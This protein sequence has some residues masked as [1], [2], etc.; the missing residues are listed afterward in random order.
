MGEPVSIATAAVSATSAACKVS[1]SL[2][3]FISSA[4]KVDKTIELLYTAV[5]RLEGSLKNVQATLQSENI[6]KATKKQHLYQ[7]SL[8]AVEHSLRDCQHTLQALA[9]ILP[10]LP[11]PEQRFDTFKKTML[12]LKLNMEQNELNSLRSNIQSHSTSLQ[13]AMQTLT[14]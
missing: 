10:E 11:P 5:I 2:Y 1:C 6:I 13:I 8:K 4:K 7:G 9:D 3:E 12:Q 14:L